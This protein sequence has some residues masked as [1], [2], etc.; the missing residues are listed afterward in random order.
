[1]AHARHLQGR[2]RVGTAARRP[3]ARL[4]EAM[5]DRRAWEQITAGPRRLAVA[6]DSEL[7]RRSPGMPIEPLRSAEPRATEQDEIAKP[8]RQPKWRSR[9]SG[10]PGLRSSGA[11]SRRSS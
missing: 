5:D 1:M 7:R 6:A 4:D 2:D 9:P 10:W 8:R 3:E 11:R